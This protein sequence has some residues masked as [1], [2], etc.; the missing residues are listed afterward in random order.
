MLLAV[1]YHVM[2]EPMSVKDILF[3]IR[4]GD[5]VA[6]VIE[7]PHSW[8]LNSRSSLVDTKVIRFAEEEATNL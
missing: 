7:G 3:L 2:F 8:K 4:D 6:H 1:L 5:E